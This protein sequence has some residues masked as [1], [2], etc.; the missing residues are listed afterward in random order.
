M[1]NIEFS[2]RGVVNLNL[3]GVDR[4][5]RFR[6]HEISLLE[7]RMGKGIMSLLSE[8]NVGLT[9]LKNAIIVGVAHEFIGKRGRK[10][11]LTEQEVAKWIDASEDNGIPFEELLETVV[12]AVVSGLPGGQ[13]YL[14]E[15]DSSGDEDGED[16][17]N[18]PAAP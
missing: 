17:G 4:R 7:Q 12:K 16:E 15:W 5:L 2:E 14:D 8:D 11:A 6:T 9:F 18:F 10:K 13:K 1:S 3:G